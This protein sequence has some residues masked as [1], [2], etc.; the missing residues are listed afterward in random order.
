MTL[1]QTHKKLQ[2]AIDFHKGANIER[3]KALYE[4]IILEDPSNE[5]AFHN[6]AQI[7]AGKGLDAVALD[8]INKA[9]AIDPA[10]AQFWISKFNLL[11]K[12]Q[13][14][15][16]LFSTFQA[17]ACYH[18]IEA[19][20]TQFLKDGVFSNLIHSIARHNCIWFLSFLSVK[21]SRAAVVEKINQLILDDPT[22][23]LRHK[24]KRFIE[25]SHK[26]ELAKERSKL[27]RMERH[28]K[29]RELVAFMDE[30]IPPG[31]RWEA[32]YLEKKA[33]ALLK[34][35]AYVECE[36]VCRYAI[37]N[38]PANTE[39]LNILAV[40]L[41]YDQNYRD[42]E[43]AWQRSLEI[44]PQNVKTYFNLG[45]MYEKKANIDSASK[46]YEEALKI[47]PN[48]VEALISMALLQ[49]KAGNITGALRNYKHCLELHPDLHMV[50]IYLSSLYLE[51]NALSEADKL[52]N[53][54]EASH[55]NHLYYRTL[56]N[57]RYRQKRYTQ[58]IE[59]LS[60]SL[61]LNASQADLHINLSICNSALGN[62]DTALTDMVKSLIMQPKLIAAW[63]AIP[64]IAGNASV[65]TRNRE[66]KK[67]LDA[68]SD[69]IDQ[70]RF[71]S[72]LETI[73]DFGISHNCSIEFP[74]IKHVSE[75]EP[76]PVYTLSNFGR[77]GTGLF[78]S[79][80][81]GHEQV[82]TTPSI[83][84]TD[85]FRPENLGF[86]LSNGLSGICDKVFETYPVFFDARR[87]EPVNSIG[88]SPIFNFGRKEGLINL[89]ENKT[90]F[91]SLNKD[92]FRTAFNIHI[93]DKSNPDLSDIFW[94]LHFAYD[95][96]HYGDLSKKRKALFYHIHNPSKYAEMTFNSQVASVN[97]LLV[98]EPLR[99][100]ESW[101]RSSFNETR[102]DYPK[103]VSRIAG[104]LRHISAPRFHK[105]S[106]YGIKLE[107]IKN[108]P[109]NTL[110]KISNHMN[111]EFSSSL[112]EMTAGGKK[113]WGDPASPN[114]DTE[115]MDPFGKEAI[116]RKLG[117]IFSDSDLVFFE[118]LLYPF[119]KHFEYDLEYVNEASFKT[120]IVKIL[121]HDDLLDFEKDVCAKL[122]INEDEFKTTGHYTF[123]RH[124]FKFRAKQL[125]E[126]GTYPH[127]ISRLC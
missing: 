80:I 76:L 105:V 100:L 65:A 112:L 126:L 125:K 60:K 72:L 29:Y 116:N 31:H 84:F 36:Q 101:L 27:E 54:I 53:E 90:D 117:L 6:L 49:H 122:S 25:P 47:D 50:K 97:Y 38:L 66:L 13:Q 51:N 30:S 108:N 43:A 33:Q 104:I 24:V 10:V 83:F 70:G 57:L 73:G 52:I 55:F 59:A 106:S 15:E 20:Y 21:V 17:F 118:T 91:F 14:W 39:F 7:L 85:F 26:N 8:H 102:P 61:N 67:L 124:M 1:E 19:V 44:D 69:K 107:D 113:W 62:H 37:L 121:E 45:K 68:C 96:V 99:T 114:Y 81:D 123:L 94:A 34:L 3:A 89:G 64:L 46:C 88:N 92:E 74:K 109:T 58:A 119:K 32:E 82:L 23:E 87:P 103:M 63:D 40:C 18:S 9:L 11:I 86:F 28:K 42:A 95:A 78:H 4:E 127:M 111:I 16:E 79:L 93:K 48:Y 41:V 115:G 75:A 110:K 71:V 12:T 35:T 5:H 22:G 2:S 56:G 77:S 98:R 120:N